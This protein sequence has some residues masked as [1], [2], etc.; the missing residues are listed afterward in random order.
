M[1]NPALQRVARTVLEAPLKAMSAGV[2]FARDQG[3][4]DIAAELTT[5]KEDWARMSSHLL[6]RIRSSE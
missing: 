1:P 3:H 6:E 4:A 5:I 2:L